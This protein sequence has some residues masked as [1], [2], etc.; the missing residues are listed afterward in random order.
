VSADRVH[1]SYGSFSTVG[2]YQSDVGY[3]GQSG[4][5]FR[6]TGQAENVGTTDCKQVLVEKK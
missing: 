1:V 6:V 5:A 3:Q 4:H 2:G